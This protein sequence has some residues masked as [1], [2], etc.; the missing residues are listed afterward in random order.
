M[1]PNWDIEE[2][3]NGETALVICETQTFDVI[4]LDQYMA[5]VEK[6]MLGTE[7][8]RALRVNGVK[9]II[10]GLSA[11]DMGS[12]FLESGADTFMMK[13]FPCQQDAMAQAVCEVLQSRDERNQCRCEMAGEA[14]GGEQ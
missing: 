7:T 3:C 13:P 4:F 10:C 14:I 8:A 1:A 5:S 6:Q 12:Q 2:A 9:C 11:N